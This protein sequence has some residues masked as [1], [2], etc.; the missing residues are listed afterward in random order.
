M[1]KAYVLIETAIGTS[2]NVV[3]QLRAVEEVLYVDRV[4][5]PHD[6]I[7]VVEVVDLPALHGLLADRVH[8][9]PGVEKT[10]TCVAVPR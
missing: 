7:A 8:P 10:I 1:L 2:P 3:G 4:T 6:I 5:G 9:L